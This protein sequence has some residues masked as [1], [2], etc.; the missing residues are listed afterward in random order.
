VPYSLYSQGDNKGT[1][2]VLNT[3]GVL[4]K[5]Y[6]H[7]KIA[8]VGGGFGA[9]IHNILEAAVYGI[10]VIFGPNYKKF[11]EAH[12]LIACGGAFSI[13]SY[14][15]L[16]RLIHKLNE[17][18]EFYEKSALAARQYVENNRGATQKIMDTIIKILE[19]GKEKR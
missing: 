19:N 12:E 4:N 3:I 17:N 14:E 1:V 9:G 10:P 5:A 18:Q 16:E 2:L 7:A 11:K 6:R 13:T 15:E 8:Y